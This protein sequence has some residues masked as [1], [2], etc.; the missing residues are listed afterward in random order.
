[1]ELFK[2]KICDDKDILYIK[3]VNIISTIDNL[4]I[5]DNSCSMG[6]NRIKL[7]S[8]A[9][10]KLINMLDNECKIAVFNDYC[11]YINN[12]DQDIKCTGC[13]DFSSVFNFILENYKNKNVN[14]ILITDGEHN[15][16]QTKLYQSLDNLI[17]NHNDQKLHLAFYC[18]GIDI[19]KSDLLM[20]ISQCGII[21]DGSLNYI[22]HESDIQETLYKVHNILCKNL[23]NIKI[24]G[25]QVKNNCLIIDEI[26]NDY[27]VN[28]EK[29]IPSEVDDET[30]LLIYK[31]ILN[32][33][34]Y[35][36]EIDFKTK[37]KIIIT[38]LDDLH[39]R[40]LNNDMSQSIRDIAKQLSQKIIE[41]DMNN[42]TFLQTRL[43]Y[44][45]SDKFVKQ[46]LKKIN[47]NFLDSCDKKCTE[48]GEI[49]KRNKGL[50]YEGDLRCSTTLD[51][52]IEL[53]ME[54]DCL[55]LGITVNRKIHGVVSG[56]IIIE[57]INSIHI[58]YES[59]K[60][61]I[62]DKSTSEEFVSSYRL[63]I[64]NSFIPLFINKEH[65][66]VA[67][68]RLYPL[69]NHL[70]TGDANC[71]QD[72]KTIYKILFKLIQ[73]IINNHTES[74]GKLTGYGEQLYG[75]I[76]DIIKTN[77]EEYKNY[78]RDIY[79]KSDFKQF[80]DKILLLIILNYYEF[81]KL[82][83]YKNKYIIIFDLIANKY[84]SKKKN[85]IEVVEYIIFE[86]KVA[87]KSESECKKIYYQNM[88]EKTLDSDK[89]TGNTLFGVKYAYKNSVVVKN[90]EKDKII[91]NWN[92]FVSTIN[93][94]IINSN[95]KQEKTIYKINIPVPDILNE[96]DNKCLYYLS[97]FMGENHTLST[98][99]RYSIINSI[100]KRY[101]NE[102]L[103]H[104]NISNEFI[105]SIFEE[106]M[107]EFRDTNDLKKAATILYH[108][109]IGNG[110]IK[111]IINYVI[112]NFD[113]FTLI[114]EKILL[115]LY[116]VYN[117]K[118][119]YDDSNIGY[120]IGIRKWKK[121]GKK[122]LTKYPNIYTHITEIVFL[123]HIRY[124][125]IIINKLNKKCNDNYI[126]TY[127]I[128]MRTI[129]IEYKLKNKNLADN[130]MSIISKTGDN[131][132]ETIRNEYEKELK[133]Y[134]NKIVKSKFILS[135]IL[136]KRYHI[137]NYFEC[138][139]DNIIKFN[140]LVQD[141]IK[142]LKIKYF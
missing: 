13:T 107:S 47:I 84:A 4:I 104:I 14:I 32:K 34:I 138:N 88:E 76:D 121:I 27:V 125:L 139:K 132:Y 75:Y 111:N 20:K 2:V 1:M 36:I 93:I 26:S 96:N 134:K 140:K 18:I 110:E 25:K 16:S 8:I 129:S 39:K 51:N 5:L 101:E 89:Q 112:E 109:K 80:D 82:Q 55:L 53:A 126:Y 79:N 106:T 61:H 3:D 19:K 49:L 46:H 123:L 29:I 30:V 90:I 116:G 7:A 73:F 64:G 124:F 6:G 56:N 142:N 128:I 10:K 108:T 41:C 9:I 103:S 24:N 137:T 50:K 48:S 77:D 141:E 97:L 136:K 118:I 65:W 122:I 105:K 102:G 72:Y 133:I 131:I 114:I 92:K 35:E 91:N 113:S 81:N 45:I 95:E 115:I 17:K 135:N 54:G 33:K 100:K 66:S 43:L 85:K 74:T 21:E 98:F 42:D 15:S 99:N 67:K 119:L 31:E 70:I 94:L 127:L 87:T 78:I 57:K 38:I 59:I 130:I 11:H 22:Q 60:N 86:T 62:N 23:N 63:S 58:S 68:H 69:V 83:D 120:N 52:P 117:E 12:L 37:Q 40:K 71:V 28:G 44:Q